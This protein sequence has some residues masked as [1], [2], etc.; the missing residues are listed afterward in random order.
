[1]KPWEYNPKIDITIKRHQAFSHYRGL[2]PQRSLVV[3]FSLYKGEPQNGA[4]VAPKYFRKWSSDSS[5][6]SRAE[7]WDKHLQEQAFRQEENSAAAT[8]QKSLKDLDSQ[9]SKL[10][11]IQLGLATR[12]ASI[13]TKELT[14]WEAEFRDTK[15]PTPEPR[16]EVED[17]RKPRYQD[18]IA[19]LK[20]IPM[21]RADGQEAWAKA[22][23]MDKLLDDMEAQAIAGEGLPDGIEWTRVV[24]G[25]PLNEDEDEDDE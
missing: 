2:G 25:V 13:A 11:Q 8:L 3:A 10:G 24:E 5:W 6:V 19:I 15:A 14:L 20:A 7:S 23:Q 4:K 12:A 18:A 1:M 9:I 17:G 21:L 16:Y 22:L